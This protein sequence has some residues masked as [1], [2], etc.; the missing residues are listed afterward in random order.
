[1]SC[2]RR[3]RSA[4]RCLAPRI[5][6]GC[7]RIG[8]ASVWAGRRW[9]RLLGCGSPGRSEN[10][11]NP[12]EEA[13]T[14]RTLRR[15]SCKGY[16][17]LGVVLHRHPVLARGAHVHPVRAHEIVLLGFL[18]DG[19]LS[20]DGRDE[21]EEAQVHLESASRRSGGWQ[22]LATENTTWRCFLQLARSDSDAPLSHNID[23]V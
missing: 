12:D 11:E 22:G 16:L 8:P 5:R 1:M 18:G 21:T 23:L 17:L 3:S 6:D 13:D 7:G 4:C 9:P 2:S 19:S 14:R 20:P 15:L 10:E